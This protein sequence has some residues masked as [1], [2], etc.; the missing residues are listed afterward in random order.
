[1]NVNGVTDI[2]LQVDG[3]LTDV[4]DGNVRVVGVVI[5]RPYIRQV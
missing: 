5:Q 1:M 3:E 2:T 4:F